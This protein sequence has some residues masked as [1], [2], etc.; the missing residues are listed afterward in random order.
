VGAH[1]FSTIATP[2]LHGRDFTGNDRR[3]RQPVTIVNEAFAERTWPNERALGKCIQIADTCYTVVGVAA[4]AKYG[5]L[6]E[7]QR[8]VFFLPIAQRAPGQFRMLLIRTSGDPSAVVPSIRRALQS[9]DDKLPYAQ[10]QTL[11]DRL[12]PELQPRRLGASMFGL[13][14]LVA[15]VLAAIGLYGVVSYSVAQRT[16]EVGIRMALGAQRG[17]VLSLVM[18]QGAVLTVTGLVLGLAAALGTTHLV[19]HLLFGVSATDPITFAG[20]CLLLAAVATLA[21]YLPARHATK[22]D[23]MIALRAE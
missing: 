13:F 11:E 16:R 8:A 21:S 10:V 18:R 3:G 14:G 4:N 5:D 2:L 17:D 12:R 19:T 23:P 9:L 6:K 7:S 20:V 15:L 22:V 1:Y